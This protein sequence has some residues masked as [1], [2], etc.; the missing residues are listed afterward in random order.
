VFVARCQNLEE[1]GEDAAPAFDDGGFFFAVFRGGS[2]FL[3]DTQ[4]LPQLV[5]ICKD[6]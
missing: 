3:I 1:V 5:S 6:Y 2:S 4:L